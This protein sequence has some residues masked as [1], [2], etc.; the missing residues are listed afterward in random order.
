MHITKANGY[1]ETRALCEQIN[2]QT[3]TE[4]MAVVHHTTGWYVNSKFLIF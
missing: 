4:M 3:S 1:M 2:H